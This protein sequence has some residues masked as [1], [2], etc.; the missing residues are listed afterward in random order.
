MN[1]RQSARSCTLEAVAGWDNLFLAAAKARRGKT[2]RPDVEDW[3][4]GRENHLRNLREALLAGA[5]QPGG[6]RFFEVFEPKRR[7]IAAAPFADRVVHHALCNVLAPALERRFIAQSFSC[8]KGKALLR[9]VNAAA[10]LPTVTRSCS[11]VTCGNSS[12]TLIMRCFW[13]CWLRSA[14]AVA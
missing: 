7:I 2:R 6:Y 13:I 5:Y 1:A 10:C 9:P 11:N 12:R 8:Q 4:L 3:W 14:V